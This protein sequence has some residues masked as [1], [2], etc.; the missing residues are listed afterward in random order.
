MAKTTRSIRTDT[1]MV[2]IFDEG[3]ATVT[4]NR[5]DLHNAFDEELISALTSALRSLEPNPEVRVV[6]L[7][8]EGKS[9]CAGAD[10]NW[11][12]RMAKY[13]RQK[14][15]A[16]AMA[17]AELMQTLNG[18]SKPTIARVQGPAYGGGVGLVAACDLAIACREATFALSE[19]RIGLIPAVISPYVIAAIGP[20]M[21]RRYMLT[22]ERFEAAEAFRIGLIQ[23]LCEIADLDGYVQLAA[24]QFLMGGPVALAASKKLLAE[25]SGRAVDERM[26]H[27]TAGRIADIRAGAEGREGIAA[28]LEK[29]DPAW[30]EQLRVKSEP[31]G[32]R[33][34]GKRKQ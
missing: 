17:L 25:V 22:G 18:L 6:V 31:S 30:V 26:A 33:K 14:N 13:S 21:A 23:E 24:T 10:L 7:A 4:L 27:D 8:A 28:F 12:R 2:E 3:I 16:D 5:P 9:F 20:R 11:M 32:K 15:L 34:P 29:R 19:V 1:V